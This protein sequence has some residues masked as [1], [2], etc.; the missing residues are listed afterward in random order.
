MPA[1]LTALVALVVAFFKARRAA[2]EK[3]TVTRQADVEAGAAQQRDADAAAEAEIVAAA[4]E[5]AD[6]TA[7]APDDANRDRFLRSIGR[8][9]ADNGG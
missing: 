7:K 5:Q 3:A 9:P 8:L 4:R 1:W 6:A 2:E